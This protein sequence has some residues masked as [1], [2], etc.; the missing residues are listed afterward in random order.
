MEAENRPTKDAYLIPNRLEDVIF[1]IQYLG[2]RESATLSAEASVETDPRSPGCTKWWQVAKDHPEFFR[3]MRDSNTI[4][5]NMRY[6]LA[7]SGKKEPLKVEL[8]QDLVKIAMA[9]QERQ[10]KR[11]EVWRGR[12]T[13]IAAVVAA[14]VGVVE[15]FLKK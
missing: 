15:L 7:G 10:A 12:I 1:L 8:I 9:I 14:V 13:L 11:V 6:A 4:N 2:L 5:L 3:V